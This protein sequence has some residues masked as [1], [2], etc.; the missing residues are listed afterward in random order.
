MYSYYL[1]SVLAHQNIEYPLRRITH[2]DNDIKS[3][4]APAKEDLHASRQMKKPRLA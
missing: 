4:K 2:E 1:G 3:A